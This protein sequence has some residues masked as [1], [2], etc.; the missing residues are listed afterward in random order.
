LR[1]NPNLV[2]ELAAHTDTRD[3]EE[4]ND[5][6]SQRRAQSVVDYLIIRGIA[7]Q[8]LVAKGYG[9]HVPLKLKKDVI[10]DGYLFTEG[11]TLDDD[12]INSLVSNN[13]KEAAHQ[14]NRRTEFRVLRKDYVPQGTNIDIADVSII[15]NP[16][17]N[18][19]RF[20]EEAKTGIYITPC[21]IDGYN[22]EFAYDK[23]SDPMISLEKA[24]DLLKWGAFSKE[25]FDGDPEE[26]LANNTIADRAV[27][28]IKEISV[29]NKTITDIKIRVNHKLRYDL[30]FGESL[31][32]QF[33]SFSFNTKTKML[34]I[35]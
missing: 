15:L 25:D 22:E 1:D 19:V 12:F 17:D 18:T 32:K 34:T 10:R 13:E 20:T 6:L 35:D 30:V 3:S 31:M 11:T 5:I 26:I 8:R 33:G 27:I 7:P 29:A 24:L 2:I 9:E 14:L 21:I 4:R 23:G 28:N 16:D